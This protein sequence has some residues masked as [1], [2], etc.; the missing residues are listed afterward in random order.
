[1]EPAPVPAALVDA[2]PSLGGET[3]GVSLQV[4]VIPREG[5]AVTRL[6]AA[7]DTLREQLT[8]PVVRP[9][10]GGYDEARRVWN[11]MID[12]RPAVIARCTNVDD[13]AAAVSFGREEG[14]PVA[15]RGGGHSAAGKGTCDSG[16]V[17]DLS[18]MNDVDVDSARR[19]V[20]AQGGVTWGQFDAATQAAGLA[21]PGGVVSTTGIGGLTLGG[22]FGWLT[23][24]FGLSCDNLISVE[25]ITAD[26]RRVVCGEDSHPDLFWALRGGGGNFGVATTL[27][28]R[29]HPVGPQVLG[30]IIG[31]PLAQATDV[32]AFHREQTR[33]LPDELGISAA[34]VTAPPLPFVPEELHDQP[35]LAAILCWSGAIDDGRDVLRPWLKLGP[36]P[37]QFV[38]TIP[39]VAMQTLL[40]ELQPPGRRSY[41]KS[42]YLTELT[43]DAIQASVSIAA[44]ARS[45]FNIAE[46]VLWGAAVARVDPDATAFGERAGRFLYN[47]VSTWEDPTDDAV[48]IP[49]ARD[50][51]D[52]MQPSATDG[53]YVNFLSDEGHERVRAAYGADTFAR[54][55]RIK[56]E[57]D[58]TNLFAINQNIPPAP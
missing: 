57:Y 40:D 47:A 22:G 7:I 29:L 12:R 52:A 54:L 37:I 53:V 11:A 31:W 42:G 17:I 8:G 23:R 30:G 43:D 46:F 34:F 5:D 35:A 28:Y 55:T 44:E 2:A 10:D 1:L 51:H 36:P 39:Y 50:F 25:L 6:E 4:R 32:L 21:A 20:R 33:G 18:P 27:E 49:W 56:A 14:L 45:P 16:I 24:R 3:A 41:W 9:D 58:P 48:H 19:T 38:D 26:G 13:V 15:V